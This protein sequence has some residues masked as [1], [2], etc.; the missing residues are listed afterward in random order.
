[1]IAAAKEMEQAGIKAIT[2][3]CGF[4]AFFQQELAGAVSVPV[5]TS[6]LLQVPLVHCM[7]KREQRIGIITA[8]KGALTPAHLEHAG[9][10]R[11]TPVSIAGME[12]TGEFAKVRTDPTATLDADKFIR[13]VVA[14]AEMLATEHQDLGAIVLE[15][16]DLPPASAAI[17]HALGLPVFDIVTLTNMVYAS[18][19]GTGW[20]HATSS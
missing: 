5:F 18:V 1:M 13:E 6:S 12:N 20:N 14:V 7:L 2:T 9:I 16:T 19:A 10:G 8:D 15:C 17:R 3:T 4:N 11:G